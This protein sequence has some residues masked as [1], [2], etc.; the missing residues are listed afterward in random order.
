LTFVATPAALTCPFCRA[1][2]RFP[3]GRIPVG[4]RV[5]CGRCRGIFTAESPPPAIRVFASAPEACPYCHVVLAIRKDLPPGKRARCFNCH[6]TFRPRGM[7]KVSAKT[8][9]GKKSS[10]TKL[11]S[12]H[13]AEQARHQESTPATS[14]PARD[15]AYYFEEDGAAEVEVVE[16]TP[17]PEPDSRVTP[18]K[19]RLPEQTPKRRTAHKVSSPQPLPE[20]KRR[21]KATAPTEPVPMPAPAAERKTRMSGA[22]AALKTPL[23]AAASDEEPAATEAAAET[24]LTAKPVPAVSMATTSSA[25]PTSQTAILPGR[26]A[27]AKPAKTSAV[28]E[29]DAVLATETRKHP[30]TEL[31]P[32]PTRPGSPVPAPKKR[33]TE[34]SAKAHAPPEPPAPA[35]KPPTRATKAAAHE[36]A[37]TRSAHA[38]APRPVHAGAADAEGDAVDEEPAAPAKP[39]AK[40]AKPE[41]APSAEPVVQVEEPPPTSEPPVDEEPVP[42]P[43]PQPKPVKPKPPPPEPVGERP[44]PPEPTVP[45]VPRTSLRPPP[46]KAGSGIP[47]QG[48]L[49]VL[50]LLLVIGAVGG[51][52]YYLLFAGG[53]IRQSVYPTDGIV[54]YQGKPAVGARVTLFPVARTQGRVFPTAKVAADGTFKLTTYEPEDGAPVGKYKVTIVRGQLEADEYAELAKNNTPEQVKR[55]AD[56]MAQD[57]LYSKYSNPRES[58]LTAEITDG[59]NRLEFKLK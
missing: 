6:G 36:P 35:A 43:R 49:V 37:P 33:P 17:A 1:A 30:T 40:A 25:T 54:T 3:G 34:L 5:C 20:P 58:G 14:L 42:V 53:I 18:R 32:E 38:R 15:D 11:T 31:D 12:E 29:S 48:I 8:R 28:V 23:P 9:L 21:T 26:S 2:M 22:S 41:P 19:T 55:I 24:G 45:A 56:K 44:E 52:I 50:A 47:L 27:P 46:K 7:L 57:P 51:G 59:P 39:H 10:G 13:L 16:E 4:R